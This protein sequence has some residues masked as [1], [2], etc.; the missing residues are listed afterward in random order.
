M[1]VAPPASDGEETPK[2]PEM[3]VQQEPAAPK[4]D[5]E[6]MEQE[7]PEPA[8]QEETLNNISQVKGKNKTSGTRCCWCRI[9]SF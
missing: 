2:E 8:I 9:S 1:E 7:E 5:E 4:D 6:P 3:T